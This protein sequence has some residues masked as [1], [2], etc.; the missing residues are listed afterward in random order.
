MTA[1][2]GQAESLVLEILRPIAALTGTAIEL[3]TRSKTGAT[4]IHATAR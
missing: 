2:H 1:V 4:Q 3:A